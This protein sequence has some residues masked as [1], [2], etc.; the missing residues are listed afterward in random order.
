MRR[1]RKGTCVTALST[2]SL[3]KQFSGDSCF[4]GAALMF[5]LSTGKSIPV[6]LLLLAS[7]AAGDCTAKTR[8]AGDA[9][10]AAIKA[11]TLVLAGDRDMFSV[12]YTVEQRQ[13]IQNAS[14]GIVPNADHFWVRLV[15]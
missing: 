5:R 6:M 13:R 1:A 12:P 3:H 14:L 8:G 2:F 7:A 15:R 4:I 11:D 10:L 9:E